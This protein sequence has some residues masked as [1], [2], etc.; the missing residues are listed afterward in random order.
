M[1]VSVMVC[2]LRVLHVTQSHSPEAGGLT[3]AVND[4]AENVVLHGGYCCIVATS[5]N[6][7]IVSDLVDFISLGDRCN[8]VSALFSSELKQSIRDIIVIKQINIIHLHG[9]WLPLQ[10]IAGRI[11]VEMKLPFILTVHGMVQSWQW[12]SK[13]WLSFVKK[14]IYSA[15][16]AYPV[17]KFATKIHAITQSEASN[18]KKIY[19]NNSC[20]V[21]T[22]AIK[23][24]ACTCD[25]NTTIVDKVIFFIGRLHPKKGVDLLLESFLAANL[26]SKWKLVIAGPKEAD[27]YVIKLHEFV[28]VHDLHEQVQFLGPVYGDEKNKLMKHA[29]ITVVPSYS[30]VVGIVNLEASAQCC[31]TVTTIETGLLDWED[32]GGVLIHPNASE[33]TEALNKI[34]CW[35]TDERKLYGESSCKLI[36]RRYSWDVV[37]LKWMCLY[38]EIR[39]FK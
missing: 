37:G 21:I 12:K 34:S 38:K 33:L 2:G 18:I 14:T 4:I 13:G 26:S 36:E 28:S 5:D 11:A 23:L 22:N 17:Y 24:D 30:E 15:L 1:L 3:S 6:A 10:L 9:Y 29:W 20:V 25:D 31:P 35:S 7:G 32:G 16:V 27:D 19:P 8:T 39:G